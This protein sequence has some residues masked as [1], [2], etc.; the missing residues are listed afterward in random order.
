M[1]KRH[2]LGLVALA[3]L[4]GCSLRP[5]T[6]SVSVAFWAEDVPALKET[7]LPSSAALVSQWQ[8]PSSDPWSPYVKTTLATAVDPMGGS[9][10]L[11]DVTR[12]EVVSQA[13]RAAARV[14]AAGLPKDA[15]WIVD[16]RGAASCMFGAQLSRASREPVSTVATFN[17][18][19]ANDGLV[20]ADETLAGLVTWAPRLPDEE[21]ARRGTHPV[22]LLDAWRLAFRDDDPGDDVYDNRYMLTAAD[23]PDVAKLQEQGITRVIYVVE[24]LDDAE[25]E[26]DD[27]HPSF[28]AWHAAGIGIHFVDLAFLEEVGAPSA[29]NMQIDWARSLA[30]RTVLVRERWTLYD[31]PFFYARARG[32]FGLS[33]GR[34]VLRPGYRGGGSYNSG[35]S[36]G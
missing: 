32:G 12:L 24:D 30:P 23:L 2:V 13:Q 10:S 5:W 29:A 25:V 18:W 34:P 27:L 20:P 35:G 17:N 33:H 36:G 11:P 6:P 4:G 7:S 14:A 22:I 31:D 9:A 21:T 3:F 1:T 28:R 8:L 26:E 15:L 16:L 19:P